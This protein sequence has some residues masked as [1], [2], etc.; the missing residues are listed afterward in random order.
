MGPLNNASAFLIQSLFD[1][2]LFIL[3]LR[4]I[5]QYL[6][7]DYYN[8]LTQFVVRMTSPVIVPLRRMI[9][10][11]WGIDFATLFVIVALTC[12][13]IT[14]IM[15]VSVR[16]F[17]APAGLFLWSLGDITALTINLFFYAIL[18]SVILSWIAPLTRTPMTAILYRLTEPLMRPARRFIPIVAGFDIS[19]I[20]VMIGLQLLKI[21]IADPL[22]QAGF[23]FGIR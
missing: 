9:P 8:P 5:F 3:L 16:K 7:V 23:H 10:G 17:P 1:L 13:K 12:L 21:L 15:F 20:P 18:M 6:R 11:F 2:Y 14:L 19:P 4:F 22:T